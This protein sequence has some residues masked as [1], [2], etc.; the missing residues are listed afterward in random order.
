MARQACKG[1]AQVNE[2]QNGNQ[3]ALISVARCRSGTTWHTPEKLEAHGVNGLF[4]IAKAGSPFELAE[5]PGGFP[6]R[7]DPIMTSRAG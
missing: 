1:R 2:S 3:I 5:D 6:R 7:N 4:A